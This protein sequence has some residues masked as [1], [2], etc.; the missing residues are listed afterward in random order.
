MPEWVKVYE[1]RMNEIAAA[2]KNKE[3]KQIKDLSKIWN[4]RVEHFNK[5]FKYQADFKYKGIKGKKNLYY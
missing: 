4:S 2:E 1:K 5:E 3:E